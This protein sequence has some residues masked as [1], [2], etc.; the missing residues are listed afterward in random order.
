MTYLNMYQ[1]YI[2][3]ENKIKA[4]KLPSTSPANAA[5]TMERLEKE[6]S[7]IRGDL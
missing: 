6:W 4:N 2:F 7:V 3:P 1:K 5:W